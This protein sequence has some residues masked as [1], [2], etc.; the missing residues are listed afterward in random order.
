METK[1]G[2]PVTG[3]DYQRLP[4][5]PAPRRLLPVQNEL[6]QNGEAVPQICDCHG[7]VQK[8]LIAL[9]EPK[10]GTVLIRRAQRFVRR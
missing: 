10:L 3:Q 4:N 9:R 5:G 1:V 2:K 7:Y 6:I 8:R